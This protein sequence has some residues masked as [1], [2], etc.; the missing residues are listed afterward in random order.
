M[1]GPE[2]VA[3]CFGDGDEDDAHDEDDM[4]GE[5]ESAEYE[6]AAGSVLL[7]AY[8]TIACEEGVTP[9]KCSMDFGPAMEDGAMDGLLLLCNDA[10]GDLCITSFGSDCGEEGTTY[11]KSIPSCFTSCSVDFL[12]V[13]F[14]EGGD[15]GDGCTFST[16]DE[17][18]VY[19]EEDSHDSHDHGSHDSHDHGSHDEDS[20]GASSA[21]QV[22]AA[23][24]VTGAA[25]ALV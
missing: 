4:C 7:T 24:M 3:R 1:A 20:S 15:A 21:A 2:C 25:M 11:V 23:A 10:G 22:L 14:V 9:P 19:G 8:E 6:Q 13:F 16:V 5:V 17:L 12:K 18:Y